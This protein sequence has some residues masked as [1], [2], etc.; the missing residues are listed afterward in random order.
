[1]TLQRYKHSTDSASIS[2]RK[3][4]FH[5]LFLIYI[6]NSYN[7]TITILPFYITYYTKLN[8]ITNR[9]T[10][11]TIL[12]SQ[13]LIYSQ[14]FRLFEKNVVTLQLKVCIN[15]QGLYTPKI[16]NKVYM[17]QENHID[18][19]LAFMESLEKLGLQLKAAEEHQKQLLARMLDMKKS[20]LT[21]QEEY[22][23]LSRKSKSLQDIIDKWRPIYLERMEMVRSIQ[24]RKR[25]NK[26]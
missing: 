20:E 1:M 2:Q 18:K 26:Q 9:M 6:N 19:A 15:Q 14:N 11:R 5:F 12:K 23:E 8:F 16:Y 25:K 17:E 13:Q 24:K 3:N 10:D 22:A 4:T 7:K 21:D